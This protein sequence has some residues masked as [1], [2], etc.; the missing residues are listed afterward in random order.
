MGHSLGGQA[1][2]SGV[3]QDTRF[4]AGVLIDG[5]LTEAPAGITDTPI[6]ILAAGREQWGDNERVL[7]DHLTGPNLAVN[8][9]GAEHAT[10]SDA[11]WLAQGAVMTGS[12]GPHKTI[13]AIR[14]Y[15][16]A[17]LDAN[18]RGQPLDSLLG[19]LSSAYPDALVTTQSQSLGNEGAEQAP[20]ARP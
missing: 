7:W 15:I 13:A 9:K 2:L 11:V 10:P 18:L 12:M 3:E 1:A 16:A 4:Q 19:R 5:V 6:L 17:F 8:L 14:S 20:A